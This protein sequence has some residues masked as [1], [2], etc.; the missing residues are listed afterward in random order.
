ML[1]GLFAEVLELERVGVDDSF[2]DLGGHSLLAARLMSRIRGV[3]GVDLPL[4]TLFG[5]PTAAGLAA[6][7]ETG[8]DGNALDV[9]LPLRPQGSGRPVFCIHPGS[10]LGWSYAGLLQYLDRDTPVYALQ[11]RG[12]TGG[13]LAQSVEEMAEDYLEQIRRVQPEGPYH[14]LGWSFGGVV[15]HA[16]SALLEERGEQVARLAL[17]DCFPVNPVS[18]REVEESMPKVRVADVHR[19]MLGLFDI[20][21][22]DEEAEQLTHETTV[23]LLTTKNSALAGL[24]ETEVAAMMHLTMN[25]TL[26]GLD[27]RPR[28][29]SAPTLILAATGG[30]H[31]HQLEPGT[32]DPYLTG[33]AV[34][35][36]Q[37]NHRHTQMMNPEPLQ[38]IGPL[39][40]GREAPADRAASHV[41]S[42]IPSHAPPHVPP[43]RVTDRR[44]GRP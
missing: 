25:H 36:Q 32:W 16:V 15:A 19:A 38:E 5:A 3:L 9:L 6:R 31:D 28:P 18:R 40:R 12:L 43:H 35:F 8:G 1:C 7:L 44:S 27:N 4:R 21:L 20:E 30:E 33:A 17:L 34:E 13:E 26:L 24:G 22:T 23:E 39:A 42:R 11:A 29:V 37:L 10:G 41:P 14:L 2:F